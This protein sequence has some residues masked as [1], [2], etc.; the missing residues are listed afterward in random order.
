MRDPVASEAAA[1]RRTVEEWC[2]AK[3]TEGWLFAAT[4]AGNRWPVGLL[5]TEAEY[6]QALERAAHVTAG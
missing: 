2:S 1:E 3:A 6:D 5:L 4:K